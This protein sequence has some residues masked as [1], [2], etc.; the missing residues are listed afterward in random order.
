MEW[1]CSKYEMLFADALYI[2]DRV[3]GGGWEAN[4][5][6]ISADRSCERVSVSAIGPD[7]EPLEWP[8]DESARLVCMVHREQCV[9]GMTAAEASAWIAEKMGEKS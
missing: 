6:P 4:C 5:Y 7:G 3:C 1:Q 2:V 8:S 9:G